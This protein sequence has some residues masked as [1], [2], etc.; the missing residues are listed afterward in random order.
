MFGLRRL[1]DEPRLESIALAL[2]KLE[3]S[4]WEAISE[5]IQS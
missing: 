2:D 5:A 1:E 3:K 4:C